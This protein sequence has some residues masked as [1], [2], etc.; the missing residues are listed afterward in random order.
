MKYLNKQE[1]C[2]IFF[3]RFFY[4]LHGNK[5]LISEVVSLRLIQKI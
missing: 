1:A 3:H 4:Y 5:F 2:E